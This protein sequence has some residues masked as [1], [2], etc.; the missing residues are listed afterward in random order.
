[1]KKLI[2]LLSSAFLIFFYSC[3]DQ[4]YPT[5]VETTQVDKL[6]KPK[7]DKPPKVEASVIKLSIGET[8]LIDNNIPTMDIEDPIVHPVINM[9]EKPFEISY[10][11]Q[12][13]VDVQNIRLELIYDAN[14]NSVRDD[15]WLESSGVVFNDWKFDA[16]GNNYSNS[17]SWDGKIFDYELFPLF[18][19]LAT[20]NFPDGYDE[21]FGD[22]YILQILAF[23]EGSSYPTLIISK[24]AYIWI[25]NAVIRSLELYVNDISITTN[26]S[27]NKV[28]PT[29]VIYLGNDVSGAYIYGSWAGLINNS[30]LRVGPSVNGVIIA[31]GN[32]FRK[33][34]SGEI[35]IEIESIVHSSGVYNPFL[36]ANWMW[37][38]NPTESIDY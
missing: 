38:E 36:N 22:H 30:I 13:S 23:S 34:L 18:D 33:N 7:K 29:A 24:K 25:S 28:T 21:S 6:E 17:I 4:T 19:Q 16:D 31:T 35:S 15:L 27:K 5:L 9:N 10:E 20:Y 2:I 11:I 12:S 26:L 8:D 32:S 14:I 3:T 37:P 1:M